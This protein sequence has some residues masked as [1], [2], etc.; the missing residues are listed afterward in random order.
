MIQTVD[1]LCRVVDN[2]GDAG[3]CWRLSRQL[4]K[5][6]SLSVR[7]WIDQPATLSAFV[8]I[9][10][11]DETL[12]QTGLI[13]IRRFEEILIESQP[14]ELVIET[15]GCDVPHVFAERMTQR[16][17]SSLWVNLEYLS[18]EDWVEGC[19][20]LPSP[21]P[22]FAIT[23]WFFFPGFTNKTGGLLREEGLLQRRQHFQYGTKQD[24]GSAAQV[25]PI[26]VSVFCY[27][28][29][30]FDALL[31][32]FEDQ[33]KI[34]GQVTL[35]SVF[36]GPAQD[37]AKRWIAAHPDH[38]IMFTF[39][40]WL[41]QSEFDEVLWSSDFNVVRGEDSFVR[42]QWAGRPFIWDIYPTEDGAHLVKMAAF[43]DRYCESLKEIETAKAI[44]K[45]WQCWVQREPEKLSEAWRQVSTMLV[46]LTFHSEQWSARLEQ[47]P[48]LT[49]TLLDFIHLQQAT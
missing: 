10:S 26:K 33:R 3:V 27:D 23:R 29:A 38:S 31:N 24:I 21:H 44:A 22:H 47:Q 2:L 11:E 32:A 39:L 1:V 36:Q 28:H 4:A 14:A 48:N 20:A 19:H 17:P 16:T 12:V 35:C 45:L 13:T 42:A 37:R 6:H 8:L 49:S 46:S 30:L 18:A 25:K 7:L 5:E 40:P 15:F 43:L 34:T 41:T 9:G